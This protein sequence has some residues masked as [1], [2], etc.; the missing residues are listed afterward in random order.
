MS[1]GSTNGQTSPPLANPN[2][3]HSLESNSAACFIRGEMVKIQLTA[4]DEQPSILEQTLE[5]FSLDRGTIVTGQVI[6]RMMIQVEEVK[7]QA[8]DRYILVYRS[9]H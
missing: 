3:K 6:V 2:Y 9:K 4:A 7:E 8:M 5:A 1:N